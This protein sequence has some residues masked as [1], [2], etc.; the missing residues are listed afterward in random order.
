[1]P[2]NTELVYVYSSTVPLG[3]VVYQDPAAGTVVDPDG[4]STVT[5]YISKGPYPAS[6][7]SGEE[8][9][10]TQAAVEAPSRSIVIAMMAFLDIPGDPVYVTDAGVNLNWD[11]HEWIGI[12]SFGSIE[13]PNETL[14]AIA[15]PFKLVIS[16]VDPSIV[17]SAYGTNYVGQDA[18]VYMAILDPHTYEFLDEPTEHCSGEMAVMTL[19]ADR[20]SGSI[21][22]ECEHRLRRLPHTLRWTDENQRTR[23]SGDLFFQFT[24]DIRGY[25]S[26]AGG[27]DISYANGTGPG[28]IGQRLR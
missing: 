14:D 13:G 20:N 15:Q 7:W 1:M 2:V 9:E 21:V 8:P 22:I 18:I 11:G 27:R 4:T 23:F 28:R 16:G 5:I 26:G 12:G 6:R 24:K 25:V 3:E 17:A 10:V 19:N